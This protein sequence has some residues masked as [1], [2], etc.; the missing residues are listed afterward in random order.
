[1]LNNEV[2]NIVIFK[3][4]ISNKCRI[5]AVKS[6]M[7]GNKTQR[8]LNLFFFSYFSNRLNEFVIVN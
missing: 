2:V 8:K 4:E 6:E 3:I 1:M 5:F 7:V